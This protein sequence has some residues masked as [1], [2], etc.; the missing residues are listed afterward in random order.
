MHPN[1]YSVTTQCSNTSFSL[2]RRLDCIY[3][4]AKKPYETKGANVSKRE[5]QAL[6]G[7]PNGIKPTQHE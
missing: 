3:F 4:N 5:W 7:A 2:M 1:S 6:L